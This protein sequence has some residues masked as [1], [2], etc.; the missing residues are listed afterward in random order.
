[1]FRSID[2]IGSFYNSSHS[3]GDEPHGYVTMAS[4]TSI[5]RF[6][7]NGKG[8]DMFE[9]SQTL[10]PAVGE[11]VERYAMQFNYPKEGE[12]IDASWNE[13]S[14][15]KADIF[16]I[17]GFDGSLREKGHHEFKL[18]YDKDTKFRWVKATTLPDKKEVWA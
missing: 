14:G 17:A 6:G 15:P 11:A 13:L 1:K 3:Y 8:A 10:W 18:Q 7:F 9:R 2:F 16:S 12:Y 4:L 5:R